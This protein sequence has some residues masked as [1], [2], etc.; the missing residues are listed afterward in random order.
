VLI[1][2]HSCLLSFLP[3]QPWSLISEV[4]LQIVMLLQLQKTQTKCHVS[5]SK[6][7]QHASQWI[8]LLLIFCDFCD[9]IFIYVKIKVRNKWFCC[10]ITLVC[11]EKFTSLVLLW[12]FLQKREL[13]IIALW[14]F[15]TRKVLR[16]YQA[17][18][19]CFN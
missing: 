13:K 16:D 2:N 1:T 17:H 5:F 11:K 14:H 4:I 19:F 3:F 6:E 18:P 15:R 10:I 9:G 12:S 7:A 8:G